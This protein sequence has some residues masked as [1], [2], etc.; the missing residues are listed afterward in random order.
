MKRTGLALA[1]LF[2]AG[3]LVADPLFC[4]ALPAEDPGARFAAPPMDCCSEEGTGACAP[5]LEK[6]AN[7]PLGPLVSTTSVLAADT[8]PSVSLQVSPPGSTVS[9][10]CATVERPPRLHLLHSQF[11]I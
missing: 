11:R 9:P 4:C 2:L 5:K 10:A 3:G 8:L 1:L 6:T 7:M